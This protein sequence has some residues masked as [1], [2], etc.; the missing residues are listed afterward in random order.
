MNHAIRQKRRRGL[1]LVELTVSMAVSTILLGGITSAMVIASRA[2]PDNTSPMSCLFM[3][4][5]GSSCLASVG[6]ALR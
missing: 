1:S 3:A 5:V 4:A 6:V 2:L